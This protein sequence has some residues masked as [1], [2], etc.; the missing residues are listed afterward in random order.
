MRRRNPNLIALALLATVAAAGT[1]CSDDGGIDLTAD[2]TVESVAEALDLITTTIPQCVTN[3]ALAKIAPAATATRV[4][5]LVAE[6]LSTE[7]VPRDFTLG[8]YFGNCTD[9]PGSLTISQV[10]HENGVTTIAIVFDAYCSLSA[11]GKAAGDKTFI[12]GSATLVDHGAPSDAG[13][14]V[15]R[16]TVETDGDGLALTRFAADG[17][18]QISDKT[19]SVSG[20]ERTYG[21]PYNYFVGVNPPTESD[22]D[23]VSIGRFV[24]TDNANDIVTTATDISVSVYETIP[25]AETTDLVVTVS[26]LVG[27]IGDSGTASF[28][29]EDGDPLVINADHAIVSGT[30]VMT[31]ASGSA[32]I[33][34]NGTNTFAID[35]NG[36]PIVDGTALDCSLFNYEDFFYVP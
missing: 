14:I 34:S 22:P 26:Q 21:T 15:S 36:E 32:A 23:G 11:G 28:A 13:P 9:T 27:S 5:D 30:A 35:V 12:S 16:R 4:P 17:V 1:R 33:A 8:T 29:T 31:G 3:V 20:Y 2:V 19:I 10:S 24:M 25:G 7:L 6:A 18:T